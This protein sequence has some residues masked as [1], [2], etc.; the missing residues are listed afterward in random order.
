MGS[1]WHCTIE[2]DI[3]TIVRPDCDLELVLPTMVW[4]N[5]IS[6]D[7]NLNETSAYL[8]NLL[9]M[10]KHITPTYWT[11]R[12]RSYRS[13][14]VLQHG[15]HQEPTDLRAAAGWVVAKIGW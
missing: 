13:P 12:L 15:I 10:L 11:E 7:L 2:H 6:S 8:L 5:L 4:Q 9:D 1:C 3:S 14:E